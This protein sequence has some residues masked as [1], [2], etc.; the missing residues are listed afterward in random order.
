[1]TTGPGAITMRAPSWLIACEWN[2]SGVQMASTCPFASAVRMDGNGMGTS[3]TESWLMPSFLNAARIATSPTPFR[4]V[5]GD[6]LARQVLRRADR[7]R[8]LD[9]D[10]LPVVGLVRPLHLTG[11]GRHDVDAGR[12][13][14]ERRHP[15]DVADVAVVVG[16][17]EH[18]VVAALEHG[19]LDLDPVLLEDPLADTEIERAG[20]SRW[21]AC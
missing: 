9:E 19:L 18:D 10:V 17:R 3:L 14:D 8:P 20:R 21:G 7:A 11:R 5:D 15:A 2:G 1:M 13:G 12:V 6:R 16:E 4:G